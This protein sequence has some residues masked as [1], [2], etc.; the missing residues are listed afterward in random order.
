[1]KSFLSFL[2]DFCTS[3]F[4]RSHICKSG[5]LESVNLFESIRRFFGRLRKK[6]DKGRAWRMASSFGPLRVIKIDS[7]GRKRLGRNRGEATKGGTGGHT[8]FGKRICLLVTR[9]ASMR[10]DLEDNGAVL[11]SDRSVVLLS[12]CDKLMM[13]DG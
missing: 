11:A 5:V 3:T 8:T 10:R 7:G 4:E 9:Y 6:R 2:A 1:M 12:N 13:C